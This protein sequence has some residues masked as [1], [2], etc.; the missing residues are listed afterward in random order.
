MK[1]TIEETSIYTE[2]FNK[3]ATTVEKKQTTL[4]EILRYAI[5]IFIALVVYMF[6][7]A[8]FGFFARVMSGSMETTLMTGDRVIFAREKDYV[9]ERGD[10]IMFT[11][12]AGDPIPTWGRSEGLCKRVIGIAGDT[13]EIKDCKV[14]LNGEELVEPYLRDCEI[15]YLPKGERY[16]KYVIPECCIFVM[17]DNR[18]SSKDSR[19]FEDGPYISV[20]RVFAKYKCTYFHAK[21]KVAPNEDGEIL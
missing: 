18:C 1:K 3:M 6:V 11:M 19:F 2:N 5:Y 9:P 20:N 21:A 16:K 15:T 10:I 7:Q 12:N 8:N 13:I 14:Y 4:F 17:G